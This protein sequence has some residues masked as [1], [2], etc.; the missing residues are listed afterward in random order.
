[1][2]KCRSQRKKNKGP[3]LRQVFI[4]FLPFGRNDS[5]NRPKSNSL[6]LFKN[7]VFLYYALVTLDY[8]QTK[9]PK[10]R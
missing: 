7:P 6:I 9:M 2:K 8:F 4:L 10:I 5:I 1:M 3:Y